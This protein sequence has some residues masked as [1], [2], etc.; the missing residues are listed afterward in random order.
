MQGNSQDAR[1][2]FCVSLTGEKL[3]EKEKEDLFDVS[4]DNKIGFHVAKELCKKLGGDLMVT[5][6]AGET[7]FT[8]YVTVKGPLHAS[9]TLQTK[10][11][12]STQE[13]SLKKLSHILV[14]TSSVIDRFAIKFTLCNK[15]ELG[16]QVQFVSSKSE[17][18]EE[19]TRLH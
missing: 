11:T 7:T 6:V 10:L 12:R 2:N 8:F 18:K 9:L 15:M 13:S 19:V 4:D 17:A 5:S 14:Y 16:P 1:L 3:S